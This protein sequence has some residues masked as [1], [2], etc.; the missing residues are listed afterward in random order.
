MFHLGSFRSVT[1][2]Y[3]C[4]VVNA[5]TDYFQN[6]LKEVNPEG[7]VQSPVLP[8]AEIDAT[9]SRKRK[10]EDEVADSQDEDS[11]AEYQWDES[12]LD[13]VEGKSEED[14]P[15]IEEKTDT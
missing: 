9:P 2:P 6:E 5:P 14:P 4:R 8:R 3:F 7:G 15:K 1:S 10:A 12:L 11:E 13:D